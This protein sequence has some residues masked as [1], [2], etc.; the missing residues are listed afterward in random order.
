MIGNAGMFPWYVV[1]VMMMPMLTTM[2]MTAKT[3]MT[4]MMTMKETNNSK[5]HTKFLCTTFQYK[6]KY[7]APSL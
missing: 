7:F 6:H 4:M 3:D 5:C 1:V 2:M